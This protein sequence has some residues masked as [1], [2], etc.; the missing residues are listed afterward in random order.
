MSK[1]SNPSPK[2][3][4]PPAVAATRAEL[5]REVDRLYRFVHEAKRLVLDQVREDRRRVA[6]HALM[7]V[8]TCAL[9]AWVIFVWGRN[10]VH[11]VR[12]LRRAL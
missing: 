2:T 5:G 8:V 4:T 10:A 6:R 1:P 12:E 9:A 11:A 3:S 7:A